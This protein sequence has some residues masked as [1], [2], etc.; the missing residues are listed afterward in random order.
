MRVHR[1]GIARD[2]DL[3]KDLEVSSSSI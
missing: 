2:E 1:F 3:S